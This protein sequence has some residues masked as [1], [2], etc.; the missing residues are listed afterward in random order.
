MKK[1]VLLNLIIIV[2]NLHASSQCVEISSSDINGATNA[3][4]SLM[5]CNLKTKKFDKAL[6]VYLT[7][8]HINDRYNVPAS[9]KNYFD[10][11]NDPSLQ[12][13]A[14]VRLS[15]RHSSDG[16][17]ASNQSAMPSIIVISQ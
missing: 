8:K 16:S 10:N 12:Q 6:M 7:F 3:L 4:K 9:V 1:I 5:E 11:I 2:F 15:L 13:L 14:K 17:S